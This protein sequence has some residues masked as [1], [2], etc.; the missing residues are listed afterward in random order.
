MPPPL[1]TYP[2]TTTIIDY[3]FPDCLAVSTHNLRLVFA[4]DPLS[5]DPKEK[6][7][8][9]FGMLKICEHVLKVQQHRTERTEV[10]AEAVHEL[11]EMIW[12]LN[13]PKSDK[14]KRLPAPMSA[15]K[16]T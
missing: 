14:K 8:T 13:G 7:H 3:I 10:V 5:V 1:M 6:L 15:P 16:K 11:A 4:S 9:V 12:K 2:P